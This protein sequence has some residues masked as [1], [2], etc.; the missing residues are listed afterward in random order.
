MYHR[1]RNRTANNLWTNS[2]FNRT[3]FSSR[4]GI[5]IGAQR[6]FVLPDEVRRFVDE[7]R[8]RRDRIR[9]MSKQVSNT[10]RPFGCRT[11]S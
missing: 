6:D 8:L 1:H 5:A 7:F 10:G 11:P 9:P 3:L 2:V 4:S